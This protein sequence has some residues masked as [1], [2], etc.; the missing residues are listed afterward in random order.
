MLIGEQGCGK[1][2]IVR[3]KLY[4]Q[5]SDVA[6]FY[7][8]SVYC[9]QFTSSRTL[10]RSINDCL[11]WKHGRTY[12]PKGNKKLICLVDD[13]NLSKVYNKLRHFSGRSIIIAKASH[14]SVVTVIVTFQTKTCISIKSNSGMYLFYVCFLRRIITVFNHLPNLSDICLIITVFLIQKLNNGGKSKM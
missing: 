9:N 6:E 11:E 12:V 8:L 5:D 2:T 10:W 3:E 14:K 4:N 1:T 7:A 13:L